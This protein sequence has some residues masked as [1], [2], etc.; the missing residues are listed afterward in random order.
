[1]RYSVL[2]GFGLTLGL[3]LSWLGLIVLLPLSALAIHAGGLGWGGF[4]HEVLTS[5][6]LAAFRVSFTTAFAAALINLVFGFLVA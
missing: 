4:W 5:R 3:T 1:M 2:P 6:V